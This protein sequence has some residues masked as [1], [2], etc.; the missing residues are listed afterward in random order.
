MGSVVE[1][2]ERPAPN[3][4]GCSLLGPPV[5][6]FLCYTRCVCLLASP[7][8]RSCCVLRACTLGVGPL[9]RSACRIVRTVCLESMARVT[10]AASAAEFDRRS[11]L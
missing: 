7:S 8:V 5:D 11:V 9:A 1:W 3:P 4:G 10:S 6:L 2:V